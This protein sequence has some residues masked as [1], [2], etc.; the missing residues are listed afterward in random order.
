MPNP[1][2]SEPSAT[3]P[4]SLQAQAEA[5]HQE[6]VHS[7]SPAPAPPAPEP[8]P[9]APDTPTPAPAP[10]PEAPPPVEDFIEALIREAA[11]DQPAEILKIPVTAKLPLKVQGEMQYQPLQE[12]LGGGMRLEDYKAKTREVAEARRELE[13]HAAQLI[14]DRARMEARE[15][16]V[17][18]ERARLREAQTNPEKWEAYQNHLRLLAEDPT[19]AKTHEEALAGR[20]RAAEDA[21]EDAARHQQRVQQG[22]AQAAQWIL[23]V[24]AEPAF[25]NVD[26]D[27]VR[28]IY[29]EQLER[30]Q[31]GLD[32]AAVRAI[33]TGEA[34][35]LSTSLGPVQQEVAALRAQVA[36]LQ[37]ATSAAAHNRATQH[38]IDRAKAPP[39]TTGQPAA[40]S[41]P[42]RKVRPFT[43]R[44]WV[45]INREW[46]SRRD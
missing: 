24:G 9:P 37:G 32:P 6:W 22:V 25:A 28:T 14:A 19:Y 17:K 4:L 21:A 23:E 11:G 31:A 43:P 30:G 15:Q 38:A 27:R 35:Y 2:P 45:D 29:A 13:Q 5:R 33:F 3:P 12:V 10:A 40:P 42:D 44:E 8:G 7:E 34:H 41:A 20:E 36:Q 46:N 26:L 39:V 18:D 16:W 1:P